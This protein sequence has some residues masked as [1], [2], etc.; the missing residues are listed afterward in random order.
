MFYV[1]LFA[2]ELTL[3]R[4]E[5]GGGYL[6]LYTDLKYVFNEIGSVCYSTDFEGSMPIMFIWVFPSMPSMH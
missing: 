2:L 3:Y 1:E 5:G 6:C 4:C